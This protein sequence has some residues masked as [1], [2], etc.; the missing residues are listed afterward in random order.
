LF[1]RIA[2]LCGAL[3]WL[4]SSF[5]GQNPA[6]SHQATSAKVAP[7]TAAPV[8]TFTALYGFGT[9]NGNDDP[10]N[11][12]FGSF[13]QG[14]DGLLYDNSQNGGVPQFGTVYS[15]TLSGTYN[16]VYD[17]INCSGSTTGCSPYGG[18]TL[19]SDGN[20]YGTTNAGGT[21][22]D[23]GAIYQ[24][25]PGGVA[26][27]LHDFMSTGDGMHPLTPPVQGNDGNFYG[28]TSAT[29]DFGQVYKVTTGS[30]YTT[31]HAFT[32]TPDGNSPFGLV[33]ASD[34]NFYG[35]TYLGGSFSNGT[36]YRIT[37]AGVLTILH[38]F[39]GTD[40][41]NSIAQ[42][43]QGTDGKLYGSA[44][45]G[46]TSSAGV[47]FRIATNGTGYTILHNL[48]GTT[49]GSTIL[50]PLFQATDGNFYGTASAGGSGSDG[51]IFKMTPGGGYSA[52]HNFIGTDGKTPEM[53]LYQHTNG[54]L[55]SATQAGGTGN[56]SGEFYSLNIGAAPFARLMPTSGKVGTSVGIFG[57][58]FTGATAVSFG[59]VPAVTFSVV[60]DTYLTATVPVGA[61]TGT[62]T[63][64]TLGGPLASNQ[65]FNV[66]PTISHLAPG[67]GPV[68]S[69]ISII[70][71]GL[72]QTSA[73]TFGGVAATSFHVVSDSKVTGVVPTGAKTGKV[74]VTTAGG[75][76]T[77][78]QTFK[79]TPTITGFTP[80]SGLIGASVTI[81][82]T[83]LTQTTAVTFGG[84]AATFSVNSDSQ[85]TATVPA[86]A[87]SGPIGIT[88]P[89]GTATSS[90]T[91]D[92]T[93]TIISFTPTHGPVGTPVMITGN[94]LTQATA[95]TFN[96]TSATFTVN[97][98]T[99]VMATVPAGATTGKIVVTTTGGTA[100][101][102]TNFRVT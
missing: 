15:M 19:G 75:K 59:G 21:G 49:D 66:I 80:P 1:S 6:D 54:I 91:F 20:F 72:T 36:V 3:V 12:E 23:D 94:S 4:T 61:L 56:D 92:V 102:A 96:G 86:G 24:V 100:T 88:T 2:T 22:P 35:T 32:N 81:T 98:D 52:V 25:T 7:L 55:Y 8:A 67:S 39:D 99:Q 29:G 71:T 34:G 42:L 40:G 76:A 37:A 62:V 87:L 93:P 38:S 89:G 95:V 65:Q 97:S 45:M 33:L 50:A 74:V 10:R 16:I 27:A 101:S 31:L 82:G 48:N 30:V 57:Q 26:T 83:G 60:S 47:V 18:V 51:T 69:T 58:G 17:F 53:G 44:S 79:V 63:V 68:G 13:A 84:I 28:T 14:R 64:T 9:I 73:V 85:V 70:G 46:G 90:G 5:A 11:P 77:S 41:S 43:I 78:M